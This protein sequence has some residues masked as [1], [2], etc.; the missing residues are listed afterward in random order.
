[1][2]E[3]NNYMM[4]EKE[5][6]NILHS[7]FKSFTGKNIDMTL[8]N[9]RLRFQKIIYIMISVGIKLQYQF[10]WH[11]RGPYS[12]SLA[13][14]G[15]KLSNQ[16]DQFIDIR[17]RIP[18]DYQKKIEDVREL[19]SNDISNTDKLELYSSILYI[20]TTYGKIS[21]EDIIEHVK[22]RKPWFDE[23]TI[24]NGLNK[25]RNSGLFLN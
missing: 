19:L 14:D 22:N 20:T 17:F 10:G 24:K 4:E 1:M 2:S 11:L 3:I 9:D 12:S 15:F 7:L 8:F 25:L 16:E 23:Q 5:R 18:Q 6:L 21:D 13:S